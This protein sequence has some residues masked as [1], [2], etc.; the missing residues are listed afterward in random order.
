MMT[1][2]FMFVKSVVV[3]GSDKVSE[4][5]LWTLDASDVRLEMKSRQELVEKE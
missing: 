4:I 3:C 5:F 2:N 1:L